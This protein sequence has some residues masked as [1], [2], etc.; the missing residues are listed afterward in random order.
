MKRVMLGMAVCASMIALAPLIF[1]LRLLHSHT[2]QGTNRLIEALH[3]P[4]SG[5]N[6]MFLFATTVPMLAD[7]LAFVFHRDSFFFFER[8]IILCAFIVPLIVLMSAPSF[9]TGSV[10]I[11]DIYLSLALA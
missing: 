2:E 11:D 7:V 4:Q 10:G 9:D 1:N 5:K 3:S 8:V 6:I